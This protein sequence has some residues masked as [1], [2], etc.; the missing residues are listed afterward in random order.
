MC[1][2]TDCSCS[3]KAVQSL[4][5]CRSSRGSKAQVHVPYAH[6]DLKHPADSHFQQP[7]GGYSFHIFRV[8][9]EPCLTWAW[10]AGLTGTLARKLML[11]FFQKLAH[12][13]TP[14]S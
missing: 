4:V 9:Q 1:S 10:V 12:L 5:S 7:A 8:F 2:R 3:A 6:L 13:T 11:T 14:I